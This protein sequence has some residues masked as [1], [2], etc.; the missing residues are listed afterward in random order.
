[1]QL[2]P[3]V[4]LG[5]C[6]TTHLKLPV[7]D[8]ALSC[9]RFHDALLTVLGVQVRAGTGGEEAALFAMDLLRMYE[10]LASVQGWRFEAS[11]PK[12]LHQWQGPGQ[13]CCCAAL[14]LGQ[15]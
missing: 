9:C 15:T 8:M 13:S 1:M 2:V 7:P 12:A 4:R 11:M 10:R 3:L 14:L 5:T 6:R